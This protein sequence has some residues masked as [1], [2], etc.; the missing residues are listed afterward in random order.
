MTLF[1]SKLISKN[2][3]IEIDFHKTKYFKYFYFDIILIPK[4]E[5]HCGL[6]VWLEILGY[7]YGFCFAD[8]RHLE[9]VSNG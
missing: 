3:F 2:K 8:K 9:E 4:N 6:M 7:H 1:W 5:D